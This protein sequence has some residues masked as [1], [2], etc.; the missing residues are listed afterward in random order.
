MFVGCQ[1]LEICLWT[2]QA[3]VLLLEQ[4]RSWFRLVGACFETSSFHSWAWNDCSYRRPLRRKCAPPPPERLVV[5]NETPITTFILSLLPSLRG[6]ILCSQPVSIPVS[7]PAVL[8]QSSQRRGESPLPAYIVLPN[9]SGLPIYFPD[10][11]FFSCIKGDLLL[12]LWANLMATD[13]F[14]LNTSCIIRGTF[15]PHPCWPPT[16]LPCSR[17][18]Q[19]IDG[20]GTHTPLPQSQPASGICQHSSKRGP[21]SY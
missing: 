20:D 17:T 1:A 16:C 11:C 15:F 8:S 3:W 6:G 10:V 12:I 19:V 7:S 21:P 9:A 4:W 5:G 2:R 13:W 14:P 18:W